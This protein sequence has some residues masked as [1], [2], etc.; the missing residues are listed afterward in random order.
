MN[1]NKKGIGADKC[2]KREEK[3]PEGALL[4]EQMAQGQ[5]SILFCIISSPKVLLFCHSSHTMSHLLCTSNYT[6]LDQQNLL[7]LTPKTCSSPGGA[8][9]GGDRSLPDQDVSSSEQFP[10]LCPAPP[11]LTH[12][13][14]PSCHCLAQMCH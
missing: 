14:T 13:T 2:E 1:N 11:L 12:S 8:Q 6:Q 4:E 9:P 5:T 3:K 10:S 7:L